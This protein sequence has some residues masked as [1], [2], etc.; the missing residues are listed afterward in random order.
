M[1]PWTER[2]GHPQGVHSASPARPRG[3]RPDPRKHARGLDMVVAAGRIPQDVVFLGLDGDGAVGVHSAGRPG[4]REARK[5]RRSGYEKM[6]GSASRD[7]VL[8]AHR[9]RTRSYRHDRLNRQRDPDRRPEPR[10][11]GDGQKGSGRALPRRAGGPSSGTRELKPTAP[12][13][14][15]G[16]FV[17]PGDGEKAATARAG[18]PT[19]TTATQ[20]RS[21]YRS[22]EKRATPR[23][24]Q[25]LGSTT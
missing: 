4:R 20:G 18:A 8:E 12:S 22:H 21:Q 16:S 13:S 7:P 6:A 1:A 2:R 25:P 10:R 19:E 17:M 9:Q 23:R 5:A 3:R 24:P 15:I 11:Q 14:S